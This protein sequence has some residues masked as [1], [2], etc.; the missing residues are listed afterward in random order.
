MSSHCPKQRTLWTYSRDGLG[1]RFGFFVIALDVR[2]AKKLVH[3]LQAKTLRLGDEK[4][5]EDEH[6]QIEA[7]K[8]EKHAIT[9]LAH[10]A[11]HRKNG[12]KECCQQAIM[13]MACMVRPT[14]FVQQQS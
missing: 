3:L 10:R 5:N 2:D 9:R 4:P 6:E 14:H 7:A 8:H 12:F 11:L 13:Y 1:S